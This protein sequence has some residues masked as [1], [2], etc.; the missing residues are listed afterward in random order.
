ML[1]RGGR[2]C[3]A[4]R[5]GVGV[6]SV[7]CVC[8]CVGWVRREGVGVGVGV[9]VGLGV[10]VG[11]GAGVG[12]DVGLGVGVGGAWAD[13]MSHPTSASARF[14]GRTPTTP[15]TP[16]LS[17][18]TPTT[19]GPRPLTPSPSPPRPA[20]PHLRLRYTMFCWD[21][22]AGK[23]GAPAVAIT[24]AVDDAKEMERA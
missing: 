17:T 16:L 6:S 15:C 24:D 1:V 11:V 9:G 2:G 5:A 23:A 10:G 3:R 14:I 7:R 18:R 19:P 22:T 20:P 8:V 12:A 4:R 13:G 21:P